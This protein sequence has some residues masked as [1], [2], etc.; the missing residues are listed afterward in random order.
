MKNFSA[1]SRYA[2]LTLTLA[3]SV[4]ALIATG[5]AYHSALSQ[6]VQDE[7]K[8][9]YEAFLT[10]KLLGHEKWLKSTG[11]KKAAAVDA[12]TYKLELFFAKGLL[13]AC[14]SVGQM[15]R[16]ADWLSKYE[17][18][19]LQNEKRIPDFQ[20]DSA[21]IVDSGTEPLNEFLRRRKDKGFYKEF[22]FTRVGFDRTYTT[23]IF[24]YSKDCADSAICREE[25][26]VLMKKVNGR[27]AVASESI[28]EA[29]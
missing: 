7:S 20:V 16:D 25:S 13:D 21:E 24:A 17:F 12:H 3:L 11:Y 9:V 26:I 1:R 4:C 5:I 14:H 2:L 15:V 23:A 8:A 22:H 29:V 18:C 10:Q 6:S 28:I 19:L 27:W